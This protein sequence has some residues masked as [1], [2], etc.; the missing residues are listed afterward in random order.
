MK[1]ILLILVILISAGVFIAFRNGDP[2]P[3]I[4]YL[5]K[6][7]Q[8]HPG[9]LKYKIYAL[10]IIPVAEAAFKRE[11]VEEYQ[12][13]R[14][15]HLSAKAQSLKFLEKIIRG[16][17]AVDS[18][19]EMQQ[20]HP[21]L[22]RQ[23]I[24]I[25]GKPEIAREI[26]YDQEQGVMTMDGVRRQILDQ[27]HDPLSL[28]FNLRK[29]NLEIG[30]KFEFNINTNQKN[31]VFSASSEP[32]ELVINNQPYQC[33]V[34]KADIRRRDK[35][36]PYHRSKVTIVFLRT[37]TENVPVLINVFASGFPIN[38]KLTGIE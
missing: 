21:L 15:Y 26:T 33:A 7:G 10:G 22:F 13:K 1:K 16:S 37:E 4:A 2:A 25:S 11:V 8:L 35:N 17:A 3:V 6:T 9:E 30:Q 38:I 27:T 19:V 24:T 32:K 34:L 20:L 14:V 12:G 5:A 31:Y 36:N 29:A 28:I 23:R 18:Y